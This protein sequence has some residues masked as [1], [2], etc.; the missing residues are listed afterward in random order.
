MRAGS[1]LDWLSLPSKPT[2]RSRFPCSYPIATIPPRQEAANIHQQAEPAKEKR[3]GSSRFPC[4]YPIATIPP[5]QEAATTHQQAEPAKEKR[6]GCSRFPCS[7]QFAFSVHSV[8]VPHPN[9]GTVLVRLR[10]TGNERVLIPPEELKLRV[11]SV[12]VFKADS[13]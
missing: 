3:T 1:A 12:E 10:I 4:S 11:R 2:G 7:R 5:R 8:V 9:A 13:E 6:T